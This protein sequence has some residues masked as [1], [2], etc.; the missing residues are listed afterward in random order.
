MMQQP[1][2]ITALT[3]ALAMSMSMLSSTAWA[4][5]SLT[6]KGDPVP[7]VEEEQ[8]PETNESGDV[9]ISE[10]AEEAV[11]DLEE[12]QSKLQDDTQQDDHS[13]SLETMASS[14]VAG[15]INGDGIVNNKDSVLLFRY[16]AGW[17]ITVDK[18]ALD[19]TGDGAVNNKDAVTLFRYVAGWPNIQLHRTQEPEA[20][21]RYDIVYH[22]Y[23]GN[24]YLTKLEIVNPNPSYYTASGLALKN[25]NVDGYIFE[26][27]FDGEGTTAEKVKKIPAGE[28]GEVELYARWTP[29]TYTIKFDSDLV[30]V[31]SKNYTIET[32]ATIQTPALSN[33]VFIGWTDD[34]GERVTYIPKGT[35]GNM[36]LHAHW[37]SKRNIATPVK[38]YEKPMV[39]ED[40]DKGSVLFIYELGKI[41][42]VPLC[43]TLQFASA[44]G[45]ATRVKHVDQTSITEET[46]KTIQE[47]VSKATTDSVSW[48]L[49]NGWDNSISISQETLDQ[50]QIDEQTAQEIARSSS[51][52]YRLD[53]TS[54]EAQVVVDD[55][56][57]AY[58]YNASNGGSNSNSSENG[59]NTSYSV[60]AQKGSDGHIG[61]EIGAEVGYEA[62]A[63]AGVPGAKASATMNA[64]ISGKL[65]TSL[66]T[67]ESY[68]TNSSTGTNSKTGKTSTEN[69]D[70]A[71]E[72]SGHDAHTTTNS[73]SWNRNEGYSN[74]NSYSKTDTVSKRISNLVATRKGYGKE[75]S[76]HGSQSSGQAF[77]KQEARENAY[78]NTVTYNKNK[79]TI[80][81]IEYI[82]DGVA[83]GY[84]R[85]VQAGTAHVFGVVG[86]DV[87]SHAY[88]TYTYTVMDDNT[89]AFLDY[90]RKSP[91]FD[92]YV[93]G[94]LSF[95]VPSLINDFVNSKILRSD[96]LRVDINT[97]KIT[98]YDGN[99]EVVVIPS[100]WRVKNND[101]TYS[102][103]KI[104]GVETQAFK[105]NTTVKS[106]AFGDYVTELP[107][108][109]F[110]G[111]TSLSDLY[112]PSL[113]KIGNRAFYGCSSM[114]KLTVP[115]DVTSMGDSAFYGVNDVKIVAST[116]NVAKAATNSG[117]KSITLD[118]S[119]ISEK[120]KDS[121]LIVPNTVK[122]FE[123]QGKRNSFQ[124]LK[125]KSDAKTTI[126][127]GVYFTSCKQVPLELSSEAVDLN[128]VSVD[129]S[130]YCMTL[131]AGT[132]NMTLFGTIAMKSGIENAVV[133]RN[134]ALSPTDQYTRGQLDMTGNVLV[135]GKIS[136]QEDHLKFTN[137]QIKTISEDEF[138]KY[139]KG[140]F[141]VKFD[142]NGGAVSKSSMDSYCGTQIGNLPTPTRD[143]YD[144]TGW[145]TVKSGDDEKNKVT[146]TTVFNDPTDVTLYAHWKQHGESGWVKTNQVPSGA[147][148]TSRKYTYTQRSFKTSS[149]S[150]MSGWIW[151]KKER[152][153]WGST[154]GPVYSDPSNGERKVWSEQYVKS[155]NYKT[156]YHYFR[157]SKSW[158]GSGGSDKSGTS[159]GS[160]YYSYDFDYELTHTGSKG[161]YST[162]YRY[163]YN[164]S[165]GNT[166]SGNYMTVWK[167]DPFTTREKV[168][169][170][171]G[172]RWY[173]QDP[174]YTHT[175]HKD[176]NKESTSKP[177]G[178]NI[179]NIVEW[180]KY[181]AK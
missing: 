73:K 147:Q 5:D 69:W 91:N 181:R 148:I 162:G 57:H 149:S 114:G 118:I 136:G 146:N 36:T 89:Y 132:V 12:D 59:Y 175:F 53:T 171:Y 70:K 40:E 168:S 108:S 95:E 37:A 94:T 7:I 154:Q 71:F 64:K 140:T 21:E 75:Y 77:Q 165:N 79:L 3:L 174:V 56:N 96:G 126:V 52:T 144:F 83:D 153:G 9:S 55:S 121:A 111:C 43:T 62:K 179:S 122:Q 131:T 103:V 23:D 82:T 158:S 22:L 24:E 129:A 116:A 102:S 155:S 150:T 13:E 151:D 15:D 33:Y 134:V 115:T 159:Y 51:N 139:I 28:S 1:K 100:Y 54:S 48:T 107:D 84:Y 164:A 128:Q 27:W 101:G 178:S 137:G 50:N 97:G 46:A 180:V 17:D 173:Y 120:L 119:N 161:N 30:E 113:K 31:P 125:L 135:C 166:Q 66:D 86:Y 63:E 80:D 6:E 49:S 141:K 112:I 145:Y 25:L 45:V 109:A 39:I 74:S 47:T 2:R 177:S 105:G 130:G 142:A 29:R 61:T 88:F 65:E 170:N 110:E 18:A 123:L 157:Y 138:E 35:T 169:D 67:H 156:V 76:E 20:E 72:L 117:A 32:G 11:E 176:E 133:C 104:T 26:G 163:Y 160:N 90:S 172:T 152:T 87:A 127:N 78:S 167:C 143:Y 60:D 98:G 81:E 124:N 14:G 8:L 106:V 58:R 44:G 41:E 93:C 19:V 16:L 10:G 4:R 38:K 34:N 42:N 92:D 85:V 99:D 68:G